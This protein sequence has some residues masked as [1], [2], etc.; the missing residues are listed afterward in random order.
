[1]GAILVL[2]IQAYILILFARSI[3]SYFPNVSRRNPIVK[4]IFDIT[5]PVLRPVRSR[6]GIQN[7]IDFSPIIVFIGLYVLMVVVQRMF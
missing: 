4:L 7:G 1:M 3:L 5:E 2:L 6:V